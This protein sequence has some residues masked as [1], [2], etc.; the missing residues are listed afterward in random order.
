MYFHGSG[1]T[2][3]KDQARYWF[4]QSANQDF[5]WGVYLCGRAAL[6]RKEYAEALK[7]FSQAAQR[8]YGPAL[9][10][11]GLIYLRGYGVPVN[12]EKAI[13]YFERGAATG[14]FFARRELA[15]LMIH[16]KLG[17]W[18]IPSGLLLFIFACVV[19]AMQLIKEERDIRLYW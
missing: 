10:W 18:K 1:A 9:L 19:A 14:S 11:L 17:V 7:W 13:S 3:D 6:S 2:L 12:L 4:E 16:G 15:K 5:I 8:E